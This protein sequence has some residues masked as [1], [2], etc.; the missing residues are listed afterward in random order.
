MDGITEIKRGHQWR[1]LLL[2]C[3]LP[4]LIAGCQK[5]QTKKQPPENNVSASLTQPSPA[6]A[7][8]P[9]AP[10]IE[11]EESVAQGAASVCQREL[12]ALAKVNQTL[13]VRK[14]EAFESL[15]Q[16]ASVYTS[17]RDDI[18]EQTRDT[19]DAL[20]KYKTQKLC[21]D[22]AQSVRQSLINRGE[23]LK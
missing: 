5:H 11:R 12:V 1:L 13:Y 6:P 22:I 3:A 14:K 17:V 18:G 10:V 23:N 9:P 16:S 21:S 2:G 15:L 4:L 8:A 20:Y 19:L 7:I